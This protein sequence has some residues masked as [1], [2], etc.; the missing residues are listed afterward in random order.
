MEVR[1]KRQKIGGKPYYSS[2]SYDE[3]MNRTVAYVLDSLNGRDELKDKNGTVC[4]RIQWECSCMQKVCGACAMVINGKPALACATFLHEGEKKLTIEPLSKFP[5][6]EDLIVD[7][8]VIFENM[9]R[10]GAWLDDDAVKVDEKYQNI[11]YQCGKC[12]KCGLC[13]EVCPNYSLG[14]RFFGAAVIPEAFL[15]YE[16]GNCNIKKEYAGHFQ[17]GCSKSGACE[18]V[19]PVGVSLLSAM[20]SLNKKQ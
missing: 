7:K 10:L 13:L 11:R 2:F 5:V 18:K 12:M 16:A 15:V 6:I 8:A 3:D 20:A 19:C 14:E 1:I 9:K 4:D 17:N